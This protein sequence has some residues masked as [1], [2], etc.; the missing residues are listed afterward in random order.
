MLVRIQSSILKTIIIIIVIIIN[1]VI[2]GGLVSQKGKKQGG[3]KLGKEPAGKSIILVGTEE[4]KQMD[5]FK[6][7]REEIKAV[8]WVFYNSLL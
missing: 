7:R 4:S 3:N 2:L 5:R 1:S 8:P 6:S